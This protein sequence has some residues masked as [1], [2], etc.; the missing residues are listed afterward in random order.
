MSILLWIGVAIVGLLSVF[1]IIDKGIV[2]KE[3][4][5][6]RDSKVGA[7]VEKTI[8]ELHDAK[9]QFVRIYGRQANGIAELVSKGLIRDNYASTGY[10]SEV[11]LDANGTITT[12]D[13]EYNVLRNGLLKVNAGIHN[14]N[15]HKK[16]TKNY[17]V[18]SN[19]QNKVKAHLL[20]KTHRANAS[21]IEQNYVDNL[22]TTRNEII[23]T[24]NIDSA[25][26]A[27]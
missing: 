10:S 9:G 11:S 26:G 24:D 19:S 8:D 22:S 3:D 16:A 14:A 1:G 17:K 15:K 4:K 20:T 6:T 7:K 25:T 18:S 13:D 27:R 5:L 21:K 2:H 23:T 12:A